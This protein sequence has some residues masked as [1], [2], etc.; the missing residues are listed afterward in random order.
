[1]RRWL[2]IGAVTLGVAVL[3]S[4]PA[5][6]EPSGTVSFAVVPETVVQGQPVAITVSGTSSQAGELVVYSLGGSTPVD[7]SA[8]CP[9]VQRKE[10]VVLADI[11]PPTPVSAGSYSQ[12]YS[13][14]P[15]YTGTYVLCGYLYDP[16][17]STDVIYAAG[18]GSF[19]ATYHV[20]VTQ[21]EPP[22]SSGFTTPPSNTASGLPPP[23]ATPPTSA[24]PEPEPHLTTLTV[25][26]HDH[27]GN[28]AAKSG[29]TDIVI[30]VGG[31]TDVTDEPVFHVSF[32]L[33]RNGH[34]Q[35]EKPVWNSGSSAEV[36]VPWSCSRPGGVY[37]YMVAATDTY[38]KTLTR[39]GK[40][41]PVSAARCRA[42]KVADARRRREEAA[43]RRARER[44]EHEPPTPQQKREEEQ[45]TARQKIES[46]QHRFCEEVLNGFAEGS[47][48]INGHVYTRC[49]TPQGVVVVKGE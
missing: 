40:F 11:A 38:G 9:A 18:T 4:S 2:I 23:S 49:L 8:R 47:S 27:R 29:H 37:T 20:T 17:T 25:K 6:A 3:A 13:F 33:K 41:H 32:V 12:T 14:T 45:D 31:A 42:L 26:A 30:Q 48:R 1:M 10:E 46:D 34:P 39:H 35:A 21:S 44:T 24:E 7:P 16:S 36:V 15:G 43:A 19:N 28:T 5:A 22:T